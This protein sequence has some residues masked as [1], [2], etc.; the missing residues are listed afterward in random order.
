MKFKKI[1]YLVFALIFVFSLSISSATAAEFRFAEKGGSITIDEDET[2]K[3]LYTAGNMVSINGNIEKGLRAAGNIVT[4]N[5]NVGESVCVGGGTVVIRGDVDGT[6]HAGG[7]NVLIEGQI[8]DDL[9][10]GGGNVTLAKSAS[11]GGDLIIAGGTVNIQ[12]PITGNIYM[13]AGEVFINSK[14]GGFV[15]AR[16]GSFRLGSEAEIGGNLKYSSSEEAE[17]AEGAVILGEIEFTQKEMKGK[18]FIKTPS[19]GFIFGLI[20]IALLVKF[21][22]ALVVGLV[23]IYVFR[24][25]VKQVVEKSLGSFW[26]SISFGFSALILTPVLCVILLI[27]VVGAWLAGLIFAAYILTI[28]LSSV[29]GFI[30]LGVW[31]IKVIKKQSEYSIG[32][33]AVVIGIIAMNIAIFIP[34]VGWLVGFIFMLISLGSLYGLIHQSLIAKK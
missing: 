33:P 11:V 29:L 7:G 12:A 17:I 1:I 30:V 6:V 9:F 16:V 19:A 2:I 26:R 25:T 32:W 4:I 18:D 20:T 28:L 21:L 14:V 22:M 24:K 34:Y 23:F 8:E 13:A 15:D 3:N 5:G 31:L 27:T 10:L